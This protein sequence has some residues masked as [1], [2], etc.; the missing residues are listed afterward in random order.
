MKKTIKT[1][2]GIGLLLAAASSNLAAFPEISF[3]PLGGPGGWMNRM[4]TPPP[5]PWVMA[6]A[7]Y[8]QPAPGYA[9][10]APQARPPLRPAR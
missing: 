2:A 7:Y 8:A 1:S 10:P 4:L 3:C 9:R 6:P 5:P